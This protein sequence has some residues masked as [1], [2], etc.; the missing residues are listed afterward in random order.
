MTKLGG[1]RGVTLF[2]PTGVSNRLLFFSLCKQWA[3]TRASFSQFLPL[4]TGLEVNCVRG[5]LLV[6]SC[7]KFQLWQESGGAK[8]KQLQQLRKSCH[9]SVGSGCETRSSRDATHPDW[10]SSEKQRRPKIGGVCGSC[11]PSASRLSNCAVRQSLPLSL[12]VSL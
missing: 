10:K 8:V 3:N 12:C 7:S 5:C 9:S 2:L 4:S 1:R 11:A 6:C